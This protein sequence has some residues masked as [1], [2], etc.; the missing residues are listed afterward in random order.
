M[1]FAALVLAMIVALPAARAADVDKARKEGEV[2][3]YANITAVEPLMK[4]FSADTGV[5]YLVAA[6][7]P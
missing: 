2:A 4:A 7:K 3:F 1:K 6:R 5:N